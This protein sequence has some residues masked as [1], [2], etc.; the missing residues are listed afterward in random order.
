MMPAGI[1]LHCHMTL[2]VILCHCMSTQ[3][4]ASRDTTAPARPTWTRQTT[5]QLVLSVHF[6]TSVS[7]AAQRLCCARLGTWPTALGCLYARC[8]LR[9][10]SVCLV[11]PLGSVH[12]VRS[13]SIAHEWGVI[14]LYLNNYWGQNHNITLCLE[15]SLKQFLVKF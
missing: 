3:V 10:S 4:T 9:A 8:V 7:Q 6:F 12:V 2:Y 13:S 11:R 15:V 14:A 1:L 5:T